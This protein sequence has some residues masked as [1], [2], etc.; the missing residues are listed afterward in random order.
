M[1]PSC[2]LLQVLLAQPEVQLNQEAQPTGRA[3]AML[4]LEE[5]AQARS[6]RDFWLCCFQ[7]NTG[8]IGIAPLSPRSAM[9]STH[10]PRCTQIPLCPQPFLPWQ[11]P[12]E[13]SKP[14]PAAPTPPNLLSPFLQATV[15]LKIVRKRSFNGI[16]PLANSL[17]QL[18]IAWLSKQELTRTLK[19]NKMI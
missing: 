9:C 6:A 15:C 4:S 2:C 12:R 16:K 14:P 8:S 11:V 5:G 7:P 18:C 13:G 3:E 17:F 19:H 10:S 1:C